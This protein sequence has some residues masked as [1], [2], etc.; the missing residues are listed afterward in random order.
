MGRALLYIA[1]LAVVVAVAVWL[2]YQ[3]SQVSIDFM[4]YRIETAVG[5]LVLAVFLV[6]VLATIG[7]RYWRLFMDAPGSIG[8]SFREGRRRRGYKALTQGMVAVAAG[9][10]EEARKW[11]RKAEVLKEEPPLTLLLAAQ[12]AQLEGDDQAAKRYF[13]AMLESDE[14]RFLGLRG[15]LMQALREGD[16]EAALDFVRRAHA[17]RPKTAWV[18]TALFDLTQ[19]T[20]DLEGAQ[21]ALKQAVRYKAL[22]APEGER[23][24]AVVLLQQAEAARRS[25]DTA[26][27]QKRARAALKLAPGLVPATILLA[28]TLIDAGRPGEAERLIERAWAGTPH[29]DLLRLYRVLAPGEALPRFEKIKRLTAGKPD[30]EASKLALAEAA[31]DAKLWGEARRYLSAAMK[32]Q[33][34]ESADGEPS[35]AVCRAMARLEELEYGDAAKARSWLVRA[36]SARRDPAWVCGSCGAIAE[37]W[38]AHCGAC[39]AFDSLSWRRAVRVSPDALAAPDGEP[40]TIEAEPGRGALVPAGETPRRDLD[41]ALT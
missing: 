7:Y 29:P 23:K 24:Q 18:L 33:E 36:A 25:G 11:A 30:H 21:Q 4:G 13:H 19:A 1:K 35:E 38:S 39:N 17:M 22:P 20:G 12:A 34:A 14:T 26:T 10:K 41:K 27:A 3:P 2:A 8:R 16:Q 31:L 40:P 9:D 37:R 5:I 32:A 15:C 6:A 28:E